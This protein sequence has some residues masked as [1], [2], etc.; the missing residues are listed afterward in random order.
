MDRRIVRAHICPKHVVKFN[1]DLSNV[2][3][4]SLNVTVIYTY[5][6]QLKSDISAAGGPWKVNVLLFFLAIEQEDD[7]TTGLV[8][9]CHDYGPCRVNSD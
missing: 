4:S 2:R 9:H 8:A 1:T 3:Y 7:D 5:N 6:L